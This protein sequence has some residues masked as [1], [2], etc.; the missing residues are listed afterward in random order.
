[1]RKSLL[2]GSLAGLLVL[3]LAGADQKS[4]GQNNPEMVLKPPAKDWTY[5]KDDPK[6]K[7]RL[8]EIHAK[9]FAKTS[10]PNVF[11]LSGVTGSIYEPGNSSYTKLNSQTV[12]F[13]ER[14]KTLTS[15]RDLTLLNLP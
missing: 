10:N 5:C 12:F 9:S 11:R 1:M 15:G 6:T 3:G 8:V 13:D 14:S 4:A 2:F 7:R